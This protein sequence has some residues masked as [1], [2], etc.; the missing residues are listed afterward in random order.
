MKIHASWNIILFAIGIIFGDILANILQLKFF[1]SWLWLVLSILLL[2]FSIIVSRVPFLLLAFA[3]GFILISFRVA[4]NFLAQD[5]Y[6]DLYNQVATISGQVSKDPDESNGKLNLA[7]NNLVLENGTKLSGTLF[8]Q[9][10]NLDVRRS[11]YLTISGELLPS[12]GTYSASIFRP[13]IVNLAR[14]EPGD[15][16]LQIRD[17]FAQGIKDYLPAKE[18]SI[19]LGYL[20]GQKSGVDESFSEALRVVGLTHIIVTS[21]AHLGI[22]I[23]VA[24]KIFGKISRFASLLFSIIFTII[25]IGITGVSASMLRASFVVILSLICWYY[26]RHIHPA[27]LILLAAATTLIIS[28]SYISELGWLLSFASFSGIMIVA[29]FLTKFFYGPQRKPGFLP[30]TI[31]STLSA[32]I[33]CIPILLY[34][35]G[36]ISLISIFAN[37]LILPTISIAMGLTFLTGV[38]AIFLPFLANLVS[39]LALIVFDYQIIVV[40]F[41]YDK[42]MF[43]VELPS[44]NPLVFLLYLPVAAIAIIKFFLYLKARRRPPSKF[45]KPMLA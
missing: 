16:F 21:G 6:Q 33:L 9:V 29:P 22:L 4:P 27:R 35:F 10:V 32:S 45:I 43:L 36:S 17:F 2:V 15:L 24:R 11:D 39:K 1:S 28:P 34:F 38:F 7:L 30:S 14:P 5:I 37:L 18:V 3:S 13:E 31:I 8:T 40:E 19:G 20:L 23:G 26:G 42:K 12:F 25:F 44:E 41:F